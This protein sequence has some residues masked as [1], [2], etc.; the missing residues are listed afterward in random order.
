MIQNLRMGHKKAQKD[1]QL[2]LMRRVI[3]CVLLLSIFAQQEAFAKTDPKPVTPL[4]IRVGAIYYDDSEAQYSAIN[5]ILSSL[6]EQSHESRR[7]RP[8]RR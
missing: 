5:E 2:V 6:E 4:V 3:G 7:H 8:R 1:S